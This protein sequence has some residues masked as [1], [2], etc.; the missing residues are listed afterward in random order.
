MNSSSLV[1][2]QSRLYSVKTAMTRATPIAKNEFCAF[3]VAPPMGIG[4]APVLE[5]VGAGGKPVAVV[6]MP[7][8]LPGEIGG[9][10]G[11]FEAVGKGADAE[12]TTMVVLV[13]TKGGRKERG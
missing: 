10:G 4:G 11:E 13:W 1:E 5:A 7:V 9:A 2:N 3:V 8:K 6:R 12:G